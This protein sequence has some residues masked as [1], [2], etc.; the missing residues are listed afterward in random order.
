LNF[1]GVRDVGVKELDRA[2]EVELG[3]TVEEDL[4]GRQALPRPGD[5][6]QPVVIPMQKALELFSVAA[7]DRH[8][9]DADPAT[10]PDH[11]FYFGVLKQG[12]VHN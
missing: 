7:R 11:T 12:Q 9:F 4:Q 6:V 10:V 8:R 3:E 5:R 2:I 1:G